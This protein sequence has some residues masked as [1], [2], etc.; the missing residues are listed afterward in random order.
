MPYTGFANSIIRSFFDHQWVLYLDSGVVATGDSF[1]KRLGHAMPSGDTVMDDLLAHVFDTDSEKLL[2]IFDRNNVSKSAGSE[3][4]RFENENG[5]WVWFEIKHK[6][7]IEEG[8]NVRV[9]LL[10]DISDSKKRERLYHQTA[11]LNK[12]G[13]WHLSLP[14]KKVDW[15]PTMFEIHGLSSSETPTYE[16]AIAFYKKGENRDRFFN[17]VEK[18]IASGDEFDETFEFVD[19]K[20]HQKWVRSIGKPVMK[21]GQ[22]TSVY[23]TVQDISEHTKMKL[24]LKGNR[25]L[26]ED[27]FNSTYQFCSLLDV[28]G[29]V[30]EVNNTALKFAGIQEADV[31]GKKFWDTFWWQNSKENQERLKQEIKKASTGQIVRYNVELWNAEKDV[32]T[33]DFSLK[34][35]EN[36][37]QAGCCNIIAEGRPIQDLVDAK[38]ALEKMIQKITKQNETLRNFAHIVSH[39]L[40]SHASNISMLSSVI[41]GS[42]GKPLSEDLKNMLADASIRLTDTLGH[43]SEVVVAQTSEES[44]YEIVN[45]RKTAV[46]ALKTVSAIVSSANAE[47]TLDIDESLHVKGVQAYVDSIFL[48][49]ITNGIKYRSQDR[50]CKMKV[51]AR[52]VDTKV[53]ISFEDNGMGIDLA[54]HGQ[55]L[56]GMYNTFHGNKDAHG[57]G[58]FITRNQIESMG[59]AIAVDSEENVGTSFKVELIKG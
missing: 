1:W 54:K 45:V 19:A 2:H 53:E 48:N 42:N 30:L 43:V 51:S 49:L 58:L 25:K 37:S 8:K 5:D 15:T 50:P 22:C 11:S 27:V 20:G 39:N 56:F 47:V 14:S 33:I 28:N 9:F 31:V 52:K 10:L 41:K 17:L 13:G 34:R 12:V 21:N 23:G 24:T 4:I 26:Y 35:I 55:K 44:D 46:E 29:T 59:G 40:R 6:D 57:I 36:A 16:K 18:T 38:E 7:L 3:I 32:T